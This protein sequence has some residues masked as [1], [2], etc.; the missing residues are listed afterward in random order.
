MWKEAIMIKNISLIYGLQGGQNLERYI[1]PTTQPNI[2]PKQ[3]TNN[4][5]PKKQAAHKNPNITNNNLSNVMTN[6]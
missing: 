6:S 1:E 4:Q 2:L 5:P 3:P